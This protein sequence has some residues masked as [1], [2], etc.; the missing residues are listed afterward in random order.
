MY[1]VRKAYC[2]QDIEEATDVDEDSEE[3]AGQ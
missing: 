1:L 2:I 3:D